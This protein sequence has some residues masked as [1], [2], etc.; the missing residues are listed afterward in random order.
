MVDLRKLRAFVVVADERHFGRAADRLFV[1]QPAL[2]QTIKSLESDLGVR[3]LDRSTRRVDLTHAGARFLERAVA[4][5][6]AVEEAV[7]EARRIDAGEEGSL[8][9]G[10][11]GSAS[12]GL[13]P[14][15][16]R[17]LGEELPLLRLDLTGDL[18]SPE[19]AARLANGSLDVGIL[20]PFDLS[21][22]LHSRVLRSEP[23][24]VAL[25]IGH[26]L[27]AD[28][29]PLASL[30]GEPFVGYLSRA[31]TMAA[32]LTEACRAAGFTPDVRNE[33]R[34][35]ATLVAFV[36]SGLGVA[37]VPQGVTHVSI[38]GVTYRTLAEDVTIDL[39]VG[40]RADAPATVDRVVDRLAA[41][42]SPDE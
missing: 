38:P 2:S 37:L 3:L 10:F 33:V 6:D 25:P 27:E 22:G 20:R 29:V 30:A 36:A 7:G 24:V 35:T 39:V 12:F 41:L 13:M 34:E 8:R 11:I 9:L 28:P 42:A 21:P 15:L 4:I 16:A 31:S 5:L 26:P 40:W 32:T 14:S 23:L 17:T 19:V 18:L 1:A